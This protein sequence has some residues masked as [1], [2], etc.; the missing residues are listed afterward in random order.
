M[1]KGVRINGKVR[2]LTELENGDQIE[3]ITRDNARPLAEWES[4]VKTGRAKSGIRRAVRAE[5]AVEFSLVGKTMLQNA[6]RDFGKKV[7]TK[8]LEKLA[9][10]FG[11]HKIDDIFAQIGEGRVPPVS[12]WKNSI[13]ILPVARNGPRLEWG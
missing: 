7:R 4:F 10:A 3:I 11:A 13:L 9:P 2:Q 1:Q 6:A 12:V 5:R 8:S